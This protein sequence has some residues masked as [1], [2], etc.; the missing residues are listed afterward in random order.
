MAASIKLMILRSYLRLILSYL[1]L[2]ATSLN[3]LPSC[4]LI[5]IHHFIYSPRLQVAIILVFLVCACL[6]LR[7]HVF[8]D[9]LKDYKPILNLSNSARNIGGQFLQAIKL[10]I[11][12]E[13]SF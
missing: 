9:F 10:S 7:K 2:K 1:H 11:L 5:F 13:L 8:I 6:Q 4:R 12:N 3:S